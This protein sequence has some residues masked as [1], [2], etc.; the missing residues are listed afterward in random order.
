[1]TDTAEPL[2]GKRIS[3]DEI[4][5]I[6]ESN[7]LRDVVEQH[8]TLRGTG[9]SL[10]GLCPFHDERTPSFT[11]NEHTNTWKCFG[12]GEGGD[13]IQFV[14]QIEGGQDFR[15]AAQLLAERSHITLQGV[16]ADDDTDRKQRE[17]RSAIY[18]VNA[19]AADFYTSCLLNDT[20]A[21]PARAFLSERH[22]TAEHAKQFGCGYAPKSGQ[23]LVTFLSENGFDLEIAEAAGLVTRSQYGKT[24]DRF[25]GRPT[26]AIRNE[27]DKVVGFGARRLFDDDRVPGKFINTSETPV[28]KK[29]EVLYGYDMA[30]TSIVKQRHVIVVEGYADV[31]ACHVAGVTNAV[32]TCG[33]AF[34]KEHLRI[35]RRSV[36]D[37]GEITFGFD[38]DKAGRKATLSV[39]EI[40]QGSVRSV[41][42]FEESNGK[43]P[44]LVR[45]IEGDEAVRS[46]VS[47]RVPLLTRVLDATIDEHPVESPDDKAYAASAAAALLTHVHDPIARN[48]YAE[49]VARRLGVR[50]GDV[51]SLIAPDRE[52]APVSRER[53]SIE[54]LPTQARAEQNLLRVFILDEPTARHLFWDNRH[55]F[56][57]S[58]GRAI[59]RGVEAAFTAEP[60]LPWLDRV[61]SYIASEADP[62]LLTLAT[63]GLPV[64]EKSLF[65]YTRGLIDQVQEIAAMGAL[66]ARSA[67]VNDAP[68]DD[69]RDG[70][71]DELIAA[72]KSTP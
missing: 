8:V 21:R 51:T 19:A 60:V 7:P 44:E 25:Q 34:T 67:A 23:A 43:D 14:M 69:A 57:T 24:Y 1:M 70:A 56:V 53:A 61:R 39:Y 66:K 15:Y 13:V 62:L 17:Q 52:Q 16:D 5:R 59:A 71:L 10:K 45:R 31:M 50:P 9:R 42:A 29:S 46:L 58:A 11:V 12:C 55:I 68:D 18:D 33:T 27:F 54:H 22:F 30:R 28:Y 3:A 72:A 40:S 38:S 63:E 2:R 47:R 20:E 65:G 49:H 37:A 41:T 6:K 35:L 26:W 32:A 64:S 48:V 36:G 4:Q